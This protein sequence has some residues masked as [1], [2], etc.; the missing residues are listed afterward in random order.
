MTNLR[1]I[2]LY[3]LKS[4][5]GGQDRGKNDKKCDHQL[6]GG[7]SLHFHERSQQYA[8]DLPGHGLGEGCQEVAIGGV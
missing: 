1:Q 4:I 3:K 6:P 5:K 7:K 2:N 8:G